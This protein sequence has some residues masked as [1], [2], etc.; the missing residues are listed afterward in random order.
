MGTY[1]YQDTPRSY[2]YAPSAPVYSA[3]ATPEKSRAFYPGAEPDKVL[4]N[5][6]VPTDAKITF[7]GAK[8]SQTG[9]AVRRFVSPSIATGFRYSYNVQATWMENGQAVTKNRSVEV[10]PGDVVQV[11][12][13]RDGVTVRAE[14]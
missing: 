2:S 11:V 8:T 7:Q 3:P 10:Q 5:V 12:F 6:T 4:I 13:T 1:I 14:N 9:G